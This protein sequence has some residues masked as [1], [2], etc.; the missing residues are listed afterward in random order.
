MRR[1]IHDL[2]AFRSA[3]KVRRRLFGSLKKPDL[4]IESR[5]KMARLGDPGK[6]Y[7]RERVTR[8]REDLFH[9]DA[10]A[11]LH[12]L[13]EGL[14]KATI[15]ELHRALRDREPGLRK[16]VEELT[17]E[18]ARLRALLTPLATLEMTATTVLAKVQALSSQYAKVDPTL[19]QT[20]VEQSD[21]DGKVLEPRARR[22]P[23]GKKPDGR[24]SKRRS[25]GSRT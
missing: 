5:T 23:A 10:T 12:H 20:P 14:R 17:G 8:F 24:R 22:V 2:L 7:L 11:T 18:A 19:L 6:H 16:E 15:D 3:D 13:R 4:K 25:G 21:G 1:G 9:A